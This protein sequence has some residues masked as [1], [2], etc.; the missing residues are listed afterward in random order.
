[1]KN[2]SSKKYVHGP[3]NLGKCII[4]HK[5]HGS[6]YPFYLLK[7]SWELCVACHADRATG[8]HVLGDAFS[9]EGHPTRGYPDPL[10]KGEELVCASCHNSHASSFPNLWEYEVESLFDLCQKCHNK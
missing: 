9:T 8:K 4:C 3:V 1:M 6:D 7:Q 5:P 10:R 2:W